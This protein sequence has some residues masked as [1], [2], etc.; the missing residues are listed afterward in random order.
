M[1]PF[2]LTKKGWTWLNLHRKSIHASTRQYNAEITSTPLD[3]PTLDRKW[4]K[5]WDSS[6]LGKF[7]RKTN[8]QDGHPKYVLPMF[9]YPSGSLHM[10]H[11][12]VYTISDVI[13]RFS[14]MRG[15]NVIHPMG[16]DAFGLPAE[17]AAIERGV[18]PAE[19]TAQNIGQMKGQLQAMNGVWDWDRVCWA[20]HIYLFIANLTSK[21]N[22][23]HVIHHTTNTRSD[24]S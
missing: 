3:F 23:A 18:D 4:Q 21:R 16:W 14:Y 6:K 1:R 17:N 19:W 24:C 9:P 5:I 11:I 2:S 8:D 15:T 7:D 10:G 13:A 12:R 22:S 20:R